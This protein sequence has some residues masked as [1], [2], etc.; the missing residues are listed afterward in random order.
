MSGSDVT[1][2]FARA[3]HGDVDAVKGAL[4]AELCRSHTPDAAGRKPRA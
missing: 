4:Y 2:L 3:Q 1:S